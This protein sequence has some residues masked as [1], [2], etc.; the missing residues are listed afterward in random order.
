MNLIK[1]L[2]TVLLMS[3]V[4]LGVFGYLDRETEKRE[5]VALRKLGG[6]CMKCKVLVSTVVASGSKIGDKTIEKLQEKCQEMTEGKPRV[7]KLCETGLLEKV[8]EA[9]EDHFDPKKFCERI[10]MCD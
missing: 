1:M 8:M 9:A 3:L 5:S 10:K 4:V 7:A 6:N 2:Q